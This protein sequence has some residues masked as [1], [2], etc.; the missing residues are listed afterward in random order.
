MRDIGNFVAHG[1]ERDQ[2]VTCDSI[3]AFVKSLE[4]YAAREHAIKNGL[5]VP[6]TKSDIEEAAFCTLGMEPAHRV[7]KEVGL[8][9]KKVK[10]I[11]R[12]AFS[13]IDHVFGTQII[14]NRVLTVNEE[15]VLRRY[16]ST[17]M[18][19]EVF[20]SE[21]L[22]REF[23]ESLVKAKLIE[24]SQKTGL[25]DLEKMLSVYAIEK[26]HLSRILLT[27]GET[28]KLYLRREW[29]EVSPLSIAASI[30]VYFS[31]GQGHRFIDVVV[32]S[33]QYSAVELCA[34]ELLAQ[35]NGQSEVTVPVE[36]GDLGLLQVL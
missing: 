34:D 36:M 10:Q 31:H 19:R 24:A 5:P 3:N 16:F 8:G 14:F 28:A 21:S 30:P 23:S 20:D 9:K 11:L 35:V 18:V 29:D 7:K 13:A 27:S 12:S 26:M 17:L 1:D 22:T 25:T 15:K 4:L 2:G 32:F 6:G 33:T